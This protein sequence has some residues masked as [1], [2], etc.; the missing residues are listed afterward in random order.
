MDVTQISQTT[1]MSLLTQPII[2]PAQQTAINLANSIQSMKRA[3]LGELRHNVNLLFDSPDPQA[4]LDIFG[5]NAASL[6]AL[7]EAF[8]Q[9]IGTIL[10]Q[11]GD[12]EGLQELQAILSK[13]KPATINPDGSAT[14]IVSTE[15]PAATETPTEIPTEEPVPNP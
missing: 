6:Y 10:T 9:F 11:A 5:S 8:G 4:V 13:V 15:E 7:N 1:N 2:S 14:I 3:V 12:T